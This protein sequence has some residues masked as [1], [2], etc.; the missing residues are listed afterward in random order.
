MYG[1][2]FVYFF[3]GIIGTGVFDSLSSVDG[4]SVADV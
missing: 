3:I 4:L 1:L 2:I